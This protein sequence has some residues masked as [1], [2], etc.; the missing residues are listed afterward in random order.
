MN[1]LV[2]G[3]G[4]RE[5]AIAWRLAQ[6]PE[7][8]RLHAAPGNPGIAQSAEC[9][10]ANSADDYLSLANAL[11]IGLTVVGPEAPLV[12][13]I[14]TAFRPAGRAIVGPTAS[15]ARLEGSKSFSKDF[16]TRAGIP[17]ARY[18]TVTTLEEARR[19][20]DQFSL[21]AVLKA[22]GLAAGK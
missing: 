6:S 16:M 15:A 7:V 2:I 1:I 10:A 18:T 17:T 11:N 8:S 3:S 9:H 14:V 21:P 20:L 13:G 12:A 4:G 5:H 22:D 19:A